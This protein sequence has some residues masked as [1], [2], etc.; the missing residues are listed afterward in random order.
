MAQSDGTVDFDSRAAFAASS[1]PRRLDDVE[2]GADK[3]RSVGCDIEAEADCIWNHARKFA[4]FQ[5]YP[6]DPGITDTVG[7]CFNDTLGDCEFVHRKNPIRKVSV[8]SPVKSVLARGVK[9][10]SRMGA[11]RLAAE[12]FSVAAQ[13][14]GN[15][16]IQEAWDL[17][18]FVHYSQ[19]LNILPYEP[20][21]PA[22][23]PVSQ[24]QSA[25]TATSAAYRVLDGRAEPGALRE[26][27]LRRKSSIVTF[28]PTRSIPTCAARPIARLPPSSR[29]FRPRTEQK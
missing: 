17:P 7:Y 22:V 14:G 2:H 15:F 24:D 4:D 10:I 12:R 28:A 5:Q 25:S 8:E 16:A 18:R 29:A 26:N 27:S 19:L 9:K 6:A 11:E 13:Y 3:W 20:L 23:R 1:P 21:D